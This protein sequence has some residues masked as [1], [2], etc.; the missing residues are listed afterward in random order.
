MCEGEGG[1]KGVCEGRGCVNGRE[2]LTPDSVRRG[3]RR[4]SVCTLH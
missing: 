2:D 4:Y 1:V 3:T